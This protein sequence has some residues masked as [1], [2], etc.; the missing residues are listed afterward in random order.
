[1]EDLTA[2]MAENQQFQDSWKTLE[3]SLAALSP[4]LIA[5]Y[6][7]IAYLAFVSGYEKGRDGHFCDTPTDYSG[8]NWD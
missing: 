6:K 7:E 8:L 5:T 3:P 1:M 4:L 2:K